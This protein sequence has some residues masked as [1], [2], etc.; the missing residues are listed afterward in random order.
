MPLVPSDSFSVRRRAGFLYPKCDNF[1]CLHTRQDQNELHMKRWFFC[2][3]QA[4]LVKRKHIGW[5]IGF[6]YW[7]NWTLYGIIPRSLYKIHLNDVSEMFNCWER[8]WIEV[9]GAATAAIFSIFINALFLASHALVYWW[10]CQFLSLFSQDNEHTELTVILC[11]QNPY[12]IF[13]HNLHN[14]T[15]IFKVI[16][17]YFPAVFKRIHNPI[18]LA[19]G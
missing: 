10:E 18:R 8:R 3:S 12:A 14:I 1:A 15:M 2:R 17:Q 9:D 13:A 7:T 11:F 5:S 16:S 4:P 6:N 19:K